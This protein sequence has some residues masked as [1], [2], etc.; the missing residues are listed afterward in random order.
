[1]T[2]RPVN[3][4]THV[5]PH[6]TGSVLISMGETRVLCT[7]M[8]E[9]KVPPFLKDS[10]QGW[11]TAEY[12]MLPASTTTRKRRDSGG[13][14]DGRSQEIQRL[15]GRSLR[16]A[17]DRTL[18]GERTFWIDCDVLTADGGTRTASITGAW[19][20]LALAVQKLMDEGVLEQNPLTS[21]VA[22][23]SVG[24]VDDEVVVDLDY[25][26]DVRAQVDF[27]VVMDDAGRFIELQGTGEERAFFPDELQEMID[28]AQQAISSLMDVQRQALNREEVAY[29]R[30]W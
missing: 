9:E 21:Q 26:H 25:A 16:A 6:A 29:G 2:H 1:M 20:A 22:A 3:I 24:L 12:A 30:D 4:K 11:V 14:I 13:K 23:I 18:L 7:C 17:V 8:V 10:K 5:M 28:A 15:I 27:N 19:V